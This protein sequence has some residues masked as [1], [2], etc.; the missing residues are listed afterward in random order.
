MTVATLF[1]DLPMPPCP[2]LL[3][4]R[5]IDARPA[6]GWIRIGFEA[7]H[8]FTN[9]VGAIQGG[10]LAAMLDDVMGPAILLHTEGRLYSPTISMTVNFLAPAKPGPLFGEGQ[11]IRLGKTVGFVEGVLMDADGGPIARA[12]ATARLVATEKALA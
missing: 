9:A 1:D 10:F 4:W 7:R 2:K 11:V 3:G 12:S 6:D 8:E 5:V